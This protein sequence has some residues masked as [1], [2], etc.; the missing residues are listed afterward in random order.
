MLSAYHS[1]IHS[2]IAVLDI[3]S[4]QIAVV[5][6]IAIALDLMTADQGKSIRVM[7]DTVH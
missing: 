7:K 1:V 3:E 5:V 6:D 4:A 2:I